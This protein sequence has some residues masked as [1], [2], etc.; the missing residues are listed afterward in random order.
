MLTESGSRLHCP[1]MHRIFKRL[2]ADAC[3]CLCRA[4][5]GMVDIVDM[6]AARS[7]LSDG[8]PLAGLMDTTTGCREILVGAFGPYEPAVSIPRPSGS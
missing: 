5:T 1:Y 3:L 7:E 8:C 6:V 2:G 4:A